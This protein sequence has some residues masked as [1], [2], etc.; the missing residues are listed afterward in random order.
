MCPVFGASVRD[1]Q[2][3]SLNS[4]LEAGPN[5]IELIPSL[6]LQS[7]KNAFGVTAD[8]AKAFLQISIALKDREYLKFI[9]WEDFHKKK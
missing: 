8:I 1:V 6:L 5:L 4:G 2:G 3:N 9:S 7:K